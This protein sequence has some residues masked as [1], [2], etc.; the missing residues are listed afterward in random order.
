MT[1]VVFRKSSPP[2]NVGERAGFSP[3][4]AQKLVNNGTARYE[5]ATVVPQ[6]AEPEAVEVKPAEII[7]PD[8]V[9][10]PIDP[11]QVP[12]ESLLSQ[13]STPKALKRK[14]SA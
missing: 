14:K 7:T 13:P 10:E 2:F 12:A 5:M 3:A 9:I 8:K 6:L 4:E 1:I 11:Y